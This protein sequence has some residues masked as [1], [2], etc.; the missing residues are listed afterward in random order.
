MS[1]GFF[2]WMSYGVTAI[3]IAVELLALR[4]RRVRALRSIDEERELET[5]D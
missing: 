5:Q 4:A 3:A 2:I 1:H